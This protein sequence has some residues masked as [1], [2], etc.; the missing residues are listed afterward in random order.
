MA[1]N[2]PNLPT[3][4]LLGF[5]RIRQGALKLVQVIQFESSL[6]FHDQLHPLHDCQEGLLSIGLPPA[7]CPQAA[8]TGWHPKVLRRRQMPRLPSPPTTTTAN[9][10][11]TKQQS[12]LLS[13]NETDRTT[14]LLP[15][16]SGSGQEEKKNKERPGGK[17]ESWLDH[18]PLHHPALTQ[19][20]FF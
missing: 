20:R 3:F 7:E 9:N 11:T 18:P 8:A 15:S 19:S 4:S 6:S 2:P 14:K 10:Q 1:C 17:K 12:L 13:E 16:K 5:D